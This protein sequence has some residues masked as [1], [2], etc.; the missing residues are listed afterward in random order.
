MDESSGRLPTGTVTFLF[1]DIEG[2]TRLVQ[3]LDP[4]SYRQLLEQHHRLLRTAFEAHGGIERAT[5]GDGFLV[6]FRDAPSA[7]SAAVAAQQSLQAYPWPAGADVRVRIGLHSGEGILGG[8]DYVGVDINLA[9]RIAAAAHGGQVVISQATRALS[10]RSLQEGV[11][12]HDLG[13]HHLKGLNRPERLH[14]VIIE[15]LHADFP[16]LRSLDSGKAHVPLRMTSF[17]GRRQDLD[18]L[19]SLLAD[20]RLITL[21]GPGGTGKTSLATEFARSMAG[22]FVDGAWF[23]DLAPLTDA[24]LI[25]PTVARTLGLTEQ[26]IRPTIDRLKDHLGGRQLLLLLD[27]FEHLL[28]AS[29]VVKDLL[30]AAPRLKVLITSRSILNLY[31]EQDFPVAPLG[32]PEPSAWVDPSRLGEYGAVALF[33]ERARAA[34]P[35]F[36]VSKENAEAVTQICVRLD[37]LPLAIELAASRVRLLEPA[38]I[39]ARLQERLPLLT[40]PA[41]LPARQRTLSGA[42]GWSYE[43]LNP[44]EQRLFTR[45]AVPAGGCTLEAA[46]AICNPGGELGIDTLEGIASLVDQSLVRRSQNVGES[47]FGM[48]ETI[49][50]YGRARLEAEGSLDE[51]GQRHLRYYCD[52]AENAEPHF[53]STQALEWVDRFEA[54]HA[55]I[56]AALSRALQIS[57]AENGLRLGAAM[58]RFWFLRG[59]LREGRSWLEAVLALETGA[60]SASRAKAYTGLGGLTYWLSDAD[61][62]ERAYTAAARF[63]QQAGDQ[64]AEAEAL[65]N[66]AFVP[67]MRGDKEEAHR[68][69]T[70]SMNL[71]SQVGRPDVVAWS[72]LALG[73]ATAAAE[74]LDALTLL[75][76]ALK[77]FQVEGD[78]FHTANALRGIA[79]ANRRLGRHQAGRAALVEALS[80]FAEGRILPYIGATLEGIATIESSAGRHLEAVRVM[81]AVASLKETTGA[82]S[83]PLTQMDPRDVEGVARRALGDEAVD[84]ALTEGRHMTLEKAVDYASHL[85]D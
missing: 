45:L 56:R 74:P 78:S 46:E 41:D 59:Y 58:W 18:N 53:F 62:T 82:A 55:N 73:V 52:L 47:R 70:A 60:V 17:V 11:G 21:V 15:G 79:E 77:S 76:E 25:V 34:N 65:Y 64:P 44:P 5:Q 66:L 75:G 30:A 13:E 22:D 26:S 27:N 39:L 85:A 14:Q 42:I 72:Q 63:Y 3:E 24:S 6:I 38:E 10:E 7:V 23:V 51:I 61:A 4:P 54:E 29:S 81:G 19:R 57:D 43:L 67:V 49:R 33:I 2:S 83:T 68:Q 12:L 71:A 32:L 80:L 1:S 8:D 9:A 40:A 16:P 31:G 20:N 36:A 48:L 69:F 35:A 37:G 50:D 84:K 28:V